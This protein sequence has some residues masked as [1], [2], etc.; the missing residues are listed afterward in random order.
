MDSWRY[1]ST[2]KMPHARRSERRGIRPEI[3]GGALTPINQLWW[4][5]AGH[6]FGDYVFQTEKMSRLKNPIQKEWAEGGYRE[7]WKLWLFAHAMIHGSLVALVTGSVLLG[8]AEVV[9]H[10]TSDQ[11]KC[12]K[13]IG[14]DMDQAVHYLSKIAWCLL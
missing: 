13:V 6:I 3:R 9:V 8:T 1:R 12:R 5:V 2:T 10:F 4:M 14:H 11:L 7:S